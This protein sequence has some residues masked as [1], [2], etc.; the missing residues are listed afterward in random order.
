MQAQMQK[1]P[2]PVVLQRI[3]VAIKGEVGAKGA[4]G[5]L[6]RIGDLELQSSLMMW[7]MYW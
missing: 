1:P 5:E 7:V 3:P 2:P 4:V 6:S